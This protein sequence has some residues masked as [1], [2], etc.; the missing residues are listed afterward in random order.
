M[1]LADNYQ[2]FDEKKAIEYFKQAFTASGYDNRTFGAPREA[3]PFE[4]VSQ[5]LAKR[6]ADD[7][8]IAA[9]FSGEIRA[10]AYFRRASIAACEMAS[11][12]SLAAPLQAMAP[13]V[14]PSTLMGSPPRLGNPSG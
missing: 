4:G 10:A 11:S 8:Q 7:P 6:L 2:A 3:Y 12:T 9:V 5:I 1:H 13:M 14:L